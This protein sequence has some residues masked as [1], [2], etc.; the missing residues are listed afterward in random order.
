MSGDQKANKK[1]MLSH[2]ALYAVGVAA[3]ALGFLI[4]VFCGILVT[5][6][7]AIVWF[8]R[9]QI[10]QNRPLMVSLVAVILG[11]LAGAVLMVAIGNDPFTSFYYLF[12]GGLKTIQRFG[13]SIASAIPLVL[14]GL[15]VAFAFRTGLFNIGGAGQMLIGG[16][17]ATCVA[18][19]L[20]LPKFLVLPIMFVAAIL[21]GGLWAAVPGVLKAKFNVHEVVSTIM[22]NWVAYWAVYYFVPA[23]LKSNLETESRTIPMTA[24]LQVQWLTDLFGGSDSFMNLGIFIA[25]GAIVL[26]AFILNRT[27]MGYELKAVGFNRHSAEY[28]G[29]PVNRNIMLSMT[30]AGALAGLA[31]FAQYCGYAS[32]MS[33]GSLPSQGYDGI[34]V[35]LLG[36]NAPWGVAVAA[37]FFGILQN[38]KGFMS[39]ATSVPPDIADTIIAVI[40]YFAA[41]SV[42]I[43]RAWDWLS[44]RKA[45]KAKGE[46]LG[47]VGNH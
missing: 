35:A 23:Y 45:Q 37:M 33:I 2:I 3:I 6:L 25:L 22:M 36:V 28:A 4:S 47:N 12:S 17:A 15:S 26:I 20:P 41:T 27:V 32:N 11:L 7:A 5:I 38:G 18:L 19:W 34:A 21:G 8:F 46:A 31:G 16:L 30:I 1:G 10:L 9:K 39:A 29:M 43:E 40:I 14:T 44:R 42:L 13:G 24:S